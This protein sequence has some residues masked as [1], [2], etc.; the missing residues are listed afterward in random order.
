MEYGAGR[1]LMNVTNCDYNK[2]YDF[3]QVPKGVGLLVLFQAGSQL[4]GD[5]LK[6]TC[7]IFLP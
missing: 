3:P 5:R 2:E 7:I 6:D 1:V 4:Q